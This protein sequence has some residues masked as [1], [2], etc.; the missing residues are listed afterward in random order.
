MKQEKVKQGEETRSSEGKVDD[1][2]NRKR[3]KETSWPMRKRGSV[4]QEGTRRNGDYS[5]I[6]K[7][8]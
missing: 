7:T 1:G 8:K 6:Q 4:R 2:R 3:L 5:N